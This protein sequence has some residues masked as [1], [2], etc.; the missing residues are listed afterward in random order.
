[1]SADRPVWRVAVVGGGLTGLAA[2]YRLQELCAAAGRPL[3]LTLCEAGP[4]AGG[5]IGTEE[6]GGYR[7][8]LG[9]DSFI[10]NKPW[11]IDLSRR[12]GIADRLISTDPRFRRS[13]V[14]RK[15]KPVAVPE[16]F[17]LLSPVRVWPVL[18]SR[19][20]SP[21]GKLRMG[22]EYFLPRRRSDEDESLASFVRRRFGR[23]ALDRLVQPLVGGIYTSDPE[24][25]S[26]AATMPRF[27]EMERTHGSLIRAL[28][29]KPPGSV[30]AEHASG[31]RYGLF[32]TFAGGI[33][34]LLSALEN[35]VA[36]NAALRLNVTVI[37]IARPAGSAG[38]DLTL[39]GG[40]RLACDAVLLAIPAHRAAQLLSGLAPAVAGLLEQIEYASSAIVVS[41]HRL[42]DVSHPLDAFGLVVPA[43]ERRRILAVSFTS[44]KFPDRAP[45]GC[46]QLRTFVGGALQPELLALSDAELTALVRGELAEI[47]GVRG[48]ADF[49]RV[50]RYEHAMPQYHV[51]HLDLVRRIELAA[52]EIPGLALAGNAYHGVGIPD[53]I[54]SAEQAAE[55]LAAP[56]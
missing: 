35:R 41:G 32:V 45:P 51:G 15:G 31:A 38:F 43:A 11:A 56:S 30:A 40:A 16:G 21:W 4:R 29:A 22:L 10:T 14:L 33:S 18:S 27:L 20:F 2:A 42:S 46:V 48:E 50:A 47:L 25:L 23:E 44:R 36:P 52:A 12:L 8:E 17:Q 7:V 39:Q 1:M 26:L 34:E 9:A 3:E 53:C 37:N 28:R 54:H 13:L 55:R 5:V 19:I 6:I 24:K 49:V